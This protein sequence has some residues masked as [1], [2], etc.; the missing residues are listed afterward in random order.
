MLKT[1][2]Q[3]SLKITVII[4]IVAVT[5]SILYLSLKPILLYLTK[6]IYCDPVDIYI[7]K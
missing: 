2:K 7:L 3:E 6:D 1:P 5:A 4:V